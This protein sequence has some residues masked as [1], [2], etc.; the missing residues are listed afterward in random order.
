MPSICF[1]ISTLIK[2]H[3][4]IFKAK[5]EPVKI[6][7][8]WLLR[9]RLSE[10]HSFFFL[11]LCWVGVHCG[12][13][14]SPCD[15]SNISYLNSLPCTIALYPHSSHSWNSLSSYHFPISIHVHTASSPYSHSHTLPNSS[16]LTGTDP[17]PPQVGPVLTS[18]FLIL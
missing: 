11:L 4:G 7:Q 16:P 18:C 8:S 12:I 6:L 10:K 5:A 9:Q 13:Y 3:P 2:W 17:L 14:K 1:Y 15:T